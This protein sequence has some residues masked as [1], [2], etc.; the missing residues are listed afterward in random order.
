MR[1]RTPFGRID[2]RTAEA[3]F[4]RSDLVVLDARDA[5]SFEQSHIDGARRVS[6]AN[7]ATVINA[8]A[9]TRPILIY[10]YHGNACQ[11]LAQTFSDFGF[12]EVYSLDGGY[13]AWRERA[14]AGGDPLSSASAP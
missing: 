5:G 12:T 9:K 14:A 11:E 10:C 1:P 7:L 6:S 3:L 13:Q 2:T 4:S 8:T